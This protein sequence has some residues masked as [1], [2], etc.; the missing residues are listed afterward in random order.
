VSDTVHTRFQRGNGEG[1]V[2]FGLHSFWGHFRHFIASAIATE[3]VDGRDWMTPDDPLA[4]I[5]R[6]ATELG[7]EPKPTLVEALGRDLYIDYV[8]DTGDDK[9]GHATEISTAS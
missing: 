8:A 9:E 5:G 2:W 6:I 3:D 7:V 1:V 4:L